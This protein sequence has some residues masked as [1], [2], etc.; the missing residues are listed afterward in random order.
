[1]ESSRDAVEILRAS[2]RTRNADPDTVVNNVIVFRDEG[3]ITKTFARASADTVQ[4]LFT[5]EQIVNGNLRSYLRGGSRRAAISVR[6][7]TRVA[8]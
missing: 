7:S 1:M 4:Q 3:H 5:R 6:G 2:T 8:T